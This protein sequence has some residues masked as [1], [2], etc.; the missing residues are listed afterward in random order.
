MFLFVFSIL[1]GPLLIYFLNHKV[2]RAGEK[3]APE[4]LFKREWFVFLFLSLWTG[5]GLILV[6]RC[7]RFPSPIPSQISVPNWAYA[8][9]TVCV[10][11]RCDDPY[12]NKNR[13]NTIS[14]TLQL[15]NI[16]D[17]NIALTDTGPESSAPASSPTTATRTS[18]STS[19]GSTTTTSLPDNNNGGSSTNVGAIAG[20]VV[21]GVVGL[22]LIGLGVFF[23]LR[24]KQQE[25]KIK[26][27]SVSDVKSVLSGGTGMQEN[28]TGTGMGYGG[29]LMGYGA[30]VSGLSPNNTGTVSTGSPQPQT[31][32]FPQPQP[33]QPYPQQLG[34]TEYGTQPWS[35]GSQKL[36]VSH[37]LIL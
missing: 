18:T 23:F 3:I 32:A 6:S 16:F 22:A 10:P 30:N 4:F 7:S 20:G 13:T 5:F 11:L 35:P 12:S 33:Y 19:P 27:G 15:A 1:V 26:N 37:R 28:G 36:Y 29:P 9:V 2:G 14:S 34:V 24:R 25:E 31:Q 21:G 17:P 8:D